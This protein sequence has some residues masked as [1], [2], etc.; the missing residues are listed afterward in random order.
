[1]AHLAA[2]RSCLE[3]LLP[4][5]W[6]KLCGHGVVILCLCERTFMCVSGTNCSTLLLLWLSSKSE[7]YNGTVPIEANVFQDACKNVGIDCVSYCG[8]KRLLVY[9]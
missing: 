2:K 3:G 7:G 1:M 6:F 5:L 4:I 8:V 9:Y